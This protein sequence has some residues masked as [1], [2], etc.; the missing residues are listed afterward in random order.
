MIRN[1][2]PLNP[3]LPYLDRLALRAG[4]LPGFCNICGHLTVF[5]VINPNLRDTV[6]CQRC[7]SS[8]RQRQIAA[9]LLKDFTRGAL[10]VPG[11]ANIRDLPRG[12]VIWIA[13]TT[14]ALRETLSQRLGENCVSSEYLDP[15][16]PSGQTR[17]GVLHVDM[18]RT[19]FADNSLDYIL[20]SDVMEHIPFVQQALQ[21]THRILKPG[22][23]HI[24]TAPFYFHRFTNEQRAVLAANGEPEHFRRPWY[25]DDPLR[26]EGALVFTVFAP[27]LLCQLEDMGF[28]ASL[29]H[30]YSPFRGILGNNGMVVVARK[31][32]EPTRTRDSIFPGDIWPPVEPSDR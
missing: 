7:R 6:N 14:M 26:A 8:N 12:T 32:A 2:W 5:E 30:V 4:R 25:H 17:D 16:L 11:F 3:P 15:S 13:E 24:F 10:K 19:H 27:E 31:A 18:Q 22:G 23:C 1:V 20:S 29:Q 9:V 28:E 21:E